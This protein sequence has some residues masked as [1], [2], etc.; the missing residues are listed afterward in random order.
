[1]LYLWTGDL[2]R[3]YAAS[4]PMTAVIGSRPALNPKVDKN[5]QIY[6]FCCNN[7]RNKRRN[8][9]SVIAIL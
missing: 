5:L 2:N 1:M 8:L 7:K 4:H 3:V 6:G 9:L